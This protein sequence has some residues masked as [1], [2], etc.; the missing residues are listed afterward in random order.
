MACLIGPLP[1]EEGDLI[2]TF[3]IVY[4]SSLTAEQ[5]EWW[6]G[7]AKHFSERIPS[8]QHIRRQS[9]AGEAEGCTAQDSGPAV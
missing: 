4:P 6:A 8:T 3:D 2:I 5:K 7:Y 1:L 9:R